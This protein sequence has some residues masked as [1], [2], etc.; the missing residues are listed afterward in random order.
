MV[1]HI[2]IAFTLQGSGKI[3]K[4]TYK[5]KIEFLNAS[6]KVN[7][8]NQKLDVH[9]KCRKVAYSVAILADSVIRAEHPIPC[10]VSALWWD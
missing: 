10:S 2:Y 8:V 3:Q 6:I 4:F 9:L 7:Y 1:M 5:S